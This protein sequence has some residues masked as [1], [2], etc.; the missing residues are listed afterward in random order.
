MLLMYIEMFRI[1]AGVAADPSADLG[2]VRNVAPV[3]HAALDLLG[4]L[5]TTALAVSKPRG[6][7]SYGRRQQEERRTVSRRRGTRHGAT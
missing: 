3:L 7:T 5:V 6:M 4:S 2:I 1:M